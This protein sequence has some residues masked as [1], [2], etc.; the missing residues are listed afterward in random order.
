VLTSPPLPSLLTSSFLLKIP[1]PLSFSLQSIVRYTILPDTSSHMHLH[2]YI[3]FV[4]SYTLSESN[5]R[6]FMSIGAGFGN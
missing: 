5:I 2:P 3:L 1:G 6:C 4:W